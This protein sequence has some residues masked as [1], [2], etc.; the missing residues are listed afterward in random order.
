MA[1]Q[2]SQWGEGVRATQPFST[3]PLLSFSLFSLVLAGTAPLQHVSAKRTQAGEEWCLPELEREKASLPLPP[4]LLSFSSP[5][6]HCTSTARVIV[7]R[8]QQAADYT[9]CGGAVPARTR[10]KER[11]RERLACFES[12][13]PLKV[14]GRTQAQTHTHNLRI[15]STAGG[16]DLPAHNGEA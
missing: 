6:R 16:T 14:H 8:F 11:E 5:G 3:P 13:D 1:H 4:P 9:C 10:K 12:T 2:G 7:C 15:P